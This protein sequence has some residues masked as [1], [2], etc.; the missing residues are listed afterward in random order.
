ML[1]KQTQR[2]I[3]RIM[4]RHTEKAF[5]EITSSIEN[6]EY[7][8]SQIMRYLATHWD[9]GDYYR[10]WWETDDDQEWY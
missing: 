3:D 7:P 8:P 6:E 9:Q 4:E 1:D 10:E 5:E 2:D